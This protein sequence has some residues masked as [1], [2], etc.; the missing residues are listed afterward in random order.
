MCA[1]SR[2]RPAGREFD[3]P[4]LEVY[5]NVCESNGFWISFEVTLFSYIQPVSFI[6]FIR[7]KKPT[8]EAE[9]EEER[10]KVLKAKENV[11]NS[12]EDDNSF[13]EPYQDSGSDWQVPSPENSGSV[14]ND[15]ENDTDDENS[16]DKVDQRR[17][18]KKQYQ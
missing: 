17:V 9:L 16:G 4:A 15:S 5:T 7:H 3:T 18:K 10:R 12:D 6:L 13:E 1:S 8:T 11:L 2:M 14:V